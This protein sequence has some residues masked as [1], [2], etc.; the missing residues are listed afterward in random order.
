M[1]TLDDNRD[2]VISGAELDTLA[3][4]H[5]ANANGVCDA[6]EVKPLSEYGIVKLSVKFERDAT[7]PDRIAYSK[8]GATF[9]DGSTRPTFDLVLHSAK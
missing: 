7:H 5:D 6:G 8:A 9:K 3:L 1:A 2:G 4:W